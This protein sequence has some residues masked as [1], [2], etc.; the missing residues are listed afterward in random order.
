MSDM[1]HPDQEGNVLADSYS[2]KSCLLRIK[3]MENDK[4]IRTFSSDEF[5]YCLKRSIEI[6]VSQKLRE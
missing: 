2:Q 4:Q 5:R 3:P 1:N 6:T